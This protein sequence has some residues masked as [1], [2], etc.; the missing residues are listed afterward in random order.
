MKELTKVEALQ[1]FQTIDK[2]LEKIGEKV[3]I[4][5]LGGLAIILQEFRKRSTFD[6]DI[7]PTPYSKPFEE[8]CKK[9]KIPLDIVTLAST[10]DL[11]TAKRTNQFSG[12]YLVV[13]AITATDLIKLK[14]ERFRKQDP[15]DIFAIIDKTVLPYPA[16]KTLVQEMLLDFIGNPKGL[17]LSAQE[18]VERKYPQSLDDFVGSVKI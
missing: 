12:K 2:E 11:E 10:V 9:L 7:A 1:L 13:E 6:I 15:E 5:V 17:L 18:V 8:I 3:Q 4:T 14:L 16:F